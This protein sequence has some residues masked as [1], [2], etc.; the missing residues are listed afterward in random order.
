M[1]LMKS[2]AASE[3]MMG[4][5]TRKTHVSATLAPMVPSESVTGRKEYQY[6][7]LPSAIPPTV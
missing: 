7:I 3:T 5:E 6:I 1:A 4:H 2:S